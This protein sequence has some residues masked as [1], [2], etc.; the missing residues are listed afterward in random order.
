MTTAISPYDI[1]AAFRMLPLAQLVESEKNPRKHFDQAKLEQLADNIGKH[2]VLTPMLARPMHLADGEYFELAAG[3]RRFRAAKMAGVSHVP[4]RLIELDDV[5]FLE[6][7]TIEN[8]QR[9]DVHPLE[10]G[11]GYQD[12]MLE[13]SYTAERI[14]ERVGRSVKYVYDRV[15]LLQLIP[16]AQE[17]FLAGK[18]SSGHS[19]LLARLKPEDQ[20]RAINP[21]DITALFT[22]DHCLWTGSSDDERGSYEHLKTCS[23]REFERWIDDNVR[24]DP[25]RDTDA[26]IFPSIAAHVVPAR[27]KKLEVV[28]ITEKHQLHPDVKDPSGKRTYG[29]T[30][31]KRADGKQKSKTCDSAVMGFIAV[32]QGRGES[33]LVCIDKK[34]CKTH[35]GAEIRARATPSK[36]SAPAGPPKKDPWQLE[37]EK[38]DAKRAEWS[39]AMPAVLEATVAHVQKMPVAALFSVILDDVGERPAAKKLMPAGKTAESM[40]RSLAFSVLHASAA[41]DYSG[42]ESFPKFAKEIGLDL[43]KVLK[44]SIAAKPAK[45][46]R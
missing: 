17:L 28:A 42:Y 15:K 31:W 8:L 16:K 45:K 27:Q 1:E 38:R 41:N 44:E 43:K 20:K 9:E 36:P 37:Q 30:M 46:S 29:P 3:H 7:L 5:A 13:A 2:G 18:M 6:V 25:T 40:L 33:F 22:I 23:V 12:L 24:L 21:D 19:I 26:L 34:N 35:W 32:G 10:E 4:V 11:K 39:K 14:A